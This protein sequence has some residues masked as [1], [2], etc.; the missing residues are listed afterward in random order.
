MELFTNKWNLTNKWGFKR[1]M[2][3]LQAN[4]RVNQKQPCN[5]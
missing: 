1:Y 2:V 4:M 3:G 5:L